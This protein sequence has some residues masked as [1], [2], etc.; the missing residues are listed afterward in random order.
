M[1]S[2]I[3]SCGLSQLHDIL[4]IIRVEF[5]GD[6]IRGSSTLRALRLLSGSGT[7][8]HTRRAERLFVRAFGVSSAQRTEVMI[9]L[10]VC[11]VSF[12]LFILH[13]YQFLTSMTVGCSIDSSLIVDLET[14]CAVQAAD[15]MTAAV[16]SMASSLVRLLESSC[17][18]DDDGR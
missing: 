18:E 3:N 7:K 12:T 17:S 6:M 8:K 11:L 14:S 13:I 9:V 16:R 10:N 1:Y 4:H 2:S 15:G 5:I